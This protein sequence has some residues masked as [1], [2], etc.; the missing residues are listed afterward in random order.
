MLFIISM[1]SW[2]Q[3]LQFWHTDELTIAG[4]KQRNSRVSN[5]KL[6]CIFYL[7]CLQCFHGVGWA[8]ERASGL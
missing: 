4:I 2:H 5:V 8:A 7:Y 3:N 1:L 6:Y